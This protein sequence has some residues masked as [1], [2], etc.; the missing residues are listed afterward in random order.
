LL[1]L[2]EMLLIEV[3]G[4]TMHRQRNPDLYDVPLLK[5]DG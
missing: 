3:A 4:P 2:V 1:F 5:F